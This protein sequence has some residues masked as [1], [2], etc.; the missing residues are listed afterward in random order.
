MP[1]DAGGLPAHLARL[2]PKRRTEAKRDSRGWPIPG[3]VSARSIANGPRPRCRLVDL[4]CQLVRKYRGTADLA[5]ERLR[6]RALIDDVCGG[7]PVTVTATAERDILGFALF[8]PWAHDWHCLAVG[9]DY[10]DPRSRYAYFATAYYGSIPLA[11][12]A[13]VRRI[14][15]GQGAADAKRSRGCV[16]TPLSGHLRQGSGPGRGVSGQRAVTA[17]SVAA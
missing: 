2:P 7:D 11:A 10:T 17:L 9:F 12:A 13:G 14:G 15:Y 16:P 3:P 8:A 5:V 6:L 4:R 1:V